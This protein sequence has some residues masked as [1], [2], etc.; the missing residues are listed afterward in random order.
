MRVH[1]NI[2][3]GINNERQDCKIGTVCVG[4]VLIGERRVNKGDKDEGIW[5]MYFIYL[6]EIEQ[7]NLLQLL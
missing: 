3:L 1:L 5:L 7:R 4:G 6:Y 2:K